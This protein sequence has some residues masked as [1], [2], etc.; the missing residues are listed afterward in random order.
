V[1]GRGLAIFLTVIFGA[2]TFGG[3]VWGQVAQMFGLP[4]AH[5]IAAACMLVAIPATWRWKLQTGQAVD[6]TPS[7]HWRLRQIGRPVTDAEGPILV[8]VEY[9]VGAGGRGAFQQEIEELGRERKQD[10][11]YAWRVF[12]DPADA[13]R[14]WELFEIESWLE[15]RLFCERVTKSDR[16][17]EERLQSLLAGPPRVKFMIAPA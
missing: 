7:G 6:F 16:N 17:S 3:A 13:T 8:V 5:V 12:E 2:M 10:G 9:R 1:R 4:A 14:I 11:A 15:C